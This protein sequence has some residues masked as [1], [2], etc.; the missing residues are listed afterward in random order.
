[1]T[2]WIASPMPGG[3]QHQ[4]GVGQGGD[5][6]LGL[7][8]ADG[9]DQHHVA[10]GALQHPDRLRRRRGQPAEVAPAGHRPDVDARVGGVVLHPH[11]VAQD[12]TA[13]ERAGR[14]DRQHADPVPPCAQARTSSFVVVDLPTPG[15]PVRPM[16][17]A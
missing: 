12:R 6:D 5:L 8:D 11:P 9:L 7:A 10:A 2:A 4:R 3:E 16:T 15:E 13:G 14:V 1:M 17:W